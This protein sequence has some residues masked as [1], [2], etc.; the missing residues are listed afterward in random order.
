MI[1]T[2]D[3]ELAA[4]CRSLRNLCFEPARRFLHQ[5]LGTNARMTNLQAALGLAQ[6]ERMPEILD[7]K[8]SMGRAYEA[9]LSGH[10]SIEL[11]VQREWARGVYWV[12][13]FVLADDVP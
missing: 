1:V 8:R 4:R 11:Q 5:E 2:D 3:A 7:R 9:R 13:R 12:F 10:R 6:V